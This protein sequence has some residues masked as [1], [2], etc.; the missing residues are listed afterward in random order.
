[1]TNTYL[2]CVLLNICTL[3]NHYNYNYAS[4]SSRIENKTS[5]IK[6]VLNSTSFGVFEIHF[7][8]NDKK[9]IH[10]AT[11]YFEIAVKLSKLRIFEEF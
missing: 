4:P 11:F 6:F 2:L 1:M 7:R 8:Q 5:C 9:I 10:F 3:K